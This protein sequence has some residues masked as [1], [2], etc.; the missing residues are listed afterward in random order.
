MMATIKFITLFQIFLINL[1]S[2][3]LNNCAFNISAWM[4]TGSLK[5][6]LCRTFPL[7]ID[8]SLLHF[9]KANTLD[10]NFTFSFFYLIFNEGGNAVGSGFKI[11]PDSGHLWPHSLS[12]SGFE[13]PSFDFLKLPPYYSPN[14]CPPS[15]Y[16]L[17]TKSNV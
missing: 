5:L 11:Y 4:L 16:K 17:F 14:F 9:Q 6:T 3:I 12:L 2:Y 15:S 8:G 10:L 1:D 7:S 13:R